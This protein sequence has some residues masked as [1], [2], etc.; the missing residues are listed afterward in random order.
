M[1]LKLTFRQALSEVNGQGRNGIWKKQDLLFETDD[2]FPKKI[3]M[4]NW[5][6]KVSVSDLVVD[7]GYVVDFDIESREYNGRWYTE[8][9]IWKIADIGSDSTNTNSINNPFDSGDDPGMFPF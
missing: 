2:K 5:S 4:T 8:L 6:D 7:K 1:Q 3:C 9:K